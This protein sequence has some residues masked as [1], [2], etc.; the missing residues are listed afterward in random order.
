MPL[1]FRSLSHGTVAFG[2]FNIET[3]MLL[4]ENNFFFADGFAGAVQELASSGGRA[5]S[6][7]WES[8]LIENRDQMGD[9][10]GAI[11]GLRYT[12]FIG[13]LYRRFP[14]PASPVSFRQKGKGMADRS[15]VLEIIAPFSVKR[16]ITLGVDRDGKRAAVGSYL[17][18]R[19][20]FQELIRY[21]WA[22][23]YPTWGEG[24]RPDYVLKMKEAVQGNPWGILEGIS[25]KD[26]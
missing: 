12:G 1:A 14:F 20:S 17:F 5:F 26:P 3:D 7:S 16:P 6:S 24:E 23:G 13:A 19:N 11:H 21:V 10:M 15:L 4:L 2:F 22:G 25:F 18:D 8:F 9:L